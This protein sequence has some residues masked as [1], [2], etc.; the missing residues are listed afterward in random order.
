M[1]ISDESK[2]EEEF[3]EDLIR[4]GD[5]FPLHWRAEAMFDKL[6]NGEE[7]EGLTQENRSVSRDDVA[8][9]LG[10]VCALCGKTITNVTRCK[11]LE[12]IDGIVQDEYGWTKPSNMYGQRVFWPVGG[13]CLKR[14]HTSVKMKETSEL[15]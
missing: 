13:K 11:W 15:F 9:T 1:T 8:I 3:Y 5:V 2:Y 14:M 7:V 4:I 12:T 10:T 6:V